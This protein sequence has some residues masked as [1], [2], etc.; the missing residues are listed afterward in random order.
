MQTFIKNVIENNR[1][2]FTTE[3]Y[4]IIINNVELAKKI[5]FLGYTNARE[6]YK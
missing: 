2:N 1:K 4:R 6:I 5:Y 3:E